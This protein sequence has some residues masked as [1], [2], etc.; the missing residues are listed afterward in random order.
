MTTCVQCCVFLLQVVLSA[1]TLN[2]PVLQSPPVCVMVVMVVVVMPR[3][4]CVRTGSD[5]AGKSPTS[6]SRDA[7]AEAPATEGSG[8]M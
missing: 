4:G 2:R 1:Q 6:S 7:D 8:L 5:T 3:P